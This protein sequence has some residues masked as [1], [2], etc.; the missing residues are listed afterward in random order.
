LA[1]FR[2][3]WHHIFPVKYLEG[4]VDNGLVNALANIAVIGPSINI[5][6]SAKAPLNYVTRY[7]ISPE[8]LDQQFI[9]RDFT[10]VPFAGYEAWTRRRAE[11]LAIQAN[12]FLTDL[13]NGI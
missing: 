6:I 7:K 1:D 3:Q 12:A 2:P 11:R 4:Q 9:D 13:R 8:K 5:R 10:A